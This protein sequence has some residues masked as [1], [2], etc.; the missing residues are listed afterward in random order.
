MLNYY[1]G[2][3]LLPY[4]FY[5]VSVYLFSDRL[6]WN[7]H[8]LEQWASFLDKTQDN[9][10]I[11]TNIKVFFLFFCNSS[12]KNFFCSED[13]RFKTKI[14]HVFIIGLSLGILEQIWILHINIASIYAD[15]IYEIELVR[16]LG[17]YYCNT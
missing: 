10:K 1:Y 9:T 3:S 2:C 8:Y 14:E 6:K 11:N 16:I 15:S 7:F 17:Y 5:C 12:L 4:A 13:T